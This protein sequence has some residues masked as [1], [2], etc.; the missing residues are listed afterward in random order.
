MLADLR[1]VAAIVAVMCT[2]TYG[3]AR[4]QQPS[5]ERS[6]AEKPQPPS[7]P[8][9]TVVGVVRD[10][11]D[12]PID[13]VEVRIAVLQRRTFTDANG[14][15]RFDDVSPGRY[16]VGARRLG[17]APQV[18]R[19]TVGNDAGGSATFELVTMSYALPPVV[20]S[21]PRGGLTG[22]IGDTAFNVL[23][24][25][26]VYLVGNGR[27]TLSDSSGTFFLDVKPGSYMLQVTSPGFAR[28]LLS[29]TIPEDSGRHV[30][31][32]MTPATGRANYR[33]AAA[34]EELRT[35]FMTRRATAR[36]YTREELNRYNVEWL[37]QIVVMGAGM[38]VADD[39][40]AL[41][42]GLWRRPVYSVTLDEVESVEVYPPGSIPSADGSIRRTRPPR[43]IDSRGT[44]QGPSGSTCPAV[45]V[46]T[47]D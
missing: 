21:S 32:W 2:V 46:W 9:R 22:I 31:V 37:K 18:R 6:P 12:V 23:R 3:P 44:Q 14:G 39:C 1:V 41:I 10:T 28:K 34:V 24:G 7:A 11:G 16:E 47:R 4:A 45:F 27:R 33:E 29:V 43:S 19:V 13:S 20:T 35:R 30:T 5:R 15:F 38:P 17:F 26:D 25:A 40:Q 36:F 42:D 8:P